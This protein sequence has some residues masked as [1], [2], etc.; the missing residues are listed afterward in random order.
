M[1]DRIRR[2]SKVVSFQSK[3]GLIK[4]LSNPNEVGVSLTME[5]L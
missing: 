5:A 2:L 1:I 4:P 3:A